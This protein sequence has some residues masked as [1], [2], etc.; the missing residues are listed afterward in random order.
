MSDFEFVG[1]SYTARSIYQDDQESINLFP[2]TDT[3]RGPDRRGVI[4]L[5]SAPGKSTLLTFSDL[6]EVR[7]LWVFSGS[8]IMIAVCGS[9]VY[10]VSISFVATKVGTL[11]TFSGPVQIADNGTDVML[12]DGLARFVYRPSTGFFANLTQALFT[13]SI[14]LT[15][16]TVTAITNGQ[17]GL[18]QTLSGSGISAGT[19]IT[20][21]GTGTGGVGTYTVSISQTVGSEAMSVLDGAFFSS[22]QVG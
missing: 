17:L 19:Q 13:A 9:S 3:K 7:G 6:A 21:F 4:A 8:K 20:A 11:G 15:T 1:E 22:S 18:F 10:S 5:Y 2:E 16:M 14:A 12:V